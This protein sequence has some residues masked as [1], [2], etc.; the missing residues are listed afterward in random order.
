MAA[1]EQLA[2]LRAL[3]SAWLGPKPIGYDAHEEWLTA[4]D[5]VQQTA[6]SN[7]MQ[8]TP[9]NMQ[10][11]AHRQWPAV[12]L[13]CAENPKLLK[14]SSQHM[15]VSCTLFIGSGWP[16]F[17]SALDTD[18]VIETRDDSQSVRALSPKLLNGNFSTETS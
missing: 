13:W 5:T 9:C 17:S 10:Q 1:V 11:S 16:S 8:R 3:G 7:N 18:H 4:T 6:C 14:R 12:F 2:L 15:F